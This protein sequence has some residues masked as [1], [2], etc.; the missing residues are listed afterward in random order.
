[1]HVIDNDFS[2][3]FRKS[4]KEVLKEVGR[5]EY[6]DFDSDLRKRFATDGLGAKRGKGFLGFVYGNDIGKVCKEFFETEQARRNG[7]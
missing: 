5:K 4:Q 7:N 2:F 1:M 3:D 6:V